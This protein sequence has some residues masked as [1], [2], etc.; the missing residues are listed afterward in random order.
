MFDLPGRGVFAYFGVTGRI[1]GKVKLHG[2]SS[3]SAPEVSSEMIDT[4]DTPRLA[5]GRKVDRGKR[6]FVASMERS[7]LLIL[8]SLRCSKPRFWYNRVPSS[9][10]KHRQLPASASLAQH[11]PSGPEPPETLFSHVPDRAQL[12]LVPTLD[13]ATP[14][15]H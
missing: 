13:N 8:Y 10:F 11:A 2:K 12:H 3:R 4:N 7:Y 5:I 1:Q 6:L 9:T 15:P 14:Q